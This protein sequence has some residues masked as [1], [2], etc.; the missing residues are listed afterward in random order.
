MDE[1]TLLIN[2]QP[3]GQNWDGDSYNIK[4]RRLLND[5]KTDRALGD[6]LKKKF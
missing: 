3:A 5:F 6:F 1:D 2:L 4:V